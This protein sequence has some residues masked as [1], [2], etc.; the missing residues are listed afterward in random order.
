MKKLNSHKDRSSRRR[1]LVQS[2]YVQHYMNNDPRHLYV[3]GL[4]DYNTLD[5]A[6][7]RKYSLTESR[8]EQL[9]NEWVQAIAKAMGKVAVEVGKAGVGVGKGIFQ[10]ITPI[11]KKLGAEAKEVALDAKNWA[12]EN[13]PAVVDGIKKFAGNAVEGSKEAIQKLT[14]LA[15]EGLDFKAMAESA[16]EEYLLAFKELS[17]KIKE[18]GLPT[19]PTEAAGALGA[20]ETEEGKKALEHGAEKAG[21]SPD[22]F[23][24]TLKSYVGQS[25]F[26]DAAVKAKEKAGEGEASE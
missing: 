2:A 4:I 11:A 22:E 16:P 17:A 10:A 21:M 5:M 23:K 6:L 9:M 20:F 3:E 1:F 14:D 25:K 7:K 15:T 26:V 13:T 24:A 18:M 12:V 8:D 19:E